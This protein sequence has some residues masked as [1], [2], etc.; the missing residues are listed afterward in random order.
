MINIKYTVTSEFMV[1]I[2]KSCLK[3]TFY[4]YAFKTSLTRLPAVLFSRLSVQEVALKATKH[5]HSAGSGVGAEGIFGPT[6]TVCTIVLGKLS[7][8]E[9]QAL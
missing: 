7:T 9:L 3:A 6:I 5:L 1:K 2:I 4:F 8:R